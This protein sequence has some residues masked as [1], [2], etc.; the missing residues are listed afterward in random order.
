MD[1]YYDFVIGAYEMSLTGMFIVKYTG[2]LQYL[3]KTSV[4]TCCISTYAQNNKSVKILT[5][6]VVE[7][8]R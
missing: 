4:L 2:H 7:V 3:S 8:A 1:A 6:L 5:Q